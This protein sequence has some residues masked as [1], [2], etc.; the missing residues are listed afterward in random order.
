MESGNPHPQFTAENKVKETLH[1][2]YLN[3]GGG[4][5]DVFYFTPIPG[6][7][8]KFDERGFQLGGSTNN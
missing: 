6:E 5:K 8:I 3:L 1:F 4:F 7:V 2:R